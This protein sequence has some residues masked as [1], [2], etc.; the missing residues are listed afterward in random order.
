MR[1]SFV[2]Q[3]NSLASIATI[4]R[5]LRQQGETG[6]RR[7]HATHPARVKPELVADAP[8]QCWSW[9][10]TKLHGPAKW[11]YHYLYVLLDIYSRYVIGWMVASPEAA[12]LAERLLADAIA[13]QG[14]QPDQLAVHADRGTSMTSKP[15]DGSGRRGFWSLAARS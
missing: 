14:V 11:T 10:I 4:Y 12:S 15:D 13:A 7:R 6:D 3:L 1:V 2:K 5:L 8:N 9:D